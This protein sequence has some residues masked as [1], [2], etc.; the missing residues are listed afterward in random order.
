MNR[1]LTSTLRRARI[2]EPAILSYG[3]RPFFFFASVYAAAA[4]GLWLLMLEGAL[5]PPEGLAPRD[6]HVHE[7][8]FGYVPAVLTGFLLTAIPNWTGRLPIRGWPLLGLIGLWAAGR[9]AVALAGSIGW[10]AAAAIDGAFLLA[11]VAA[12][13]REIVAGRNLKNLVVVAV[14]SLL[15]AANL[16]FHLEAHL[17]G[18][19]ETSVRA[20]IA[21][22]VLLIALIGGRIIP[23]FTLNWLTRRGARHAPAPFGAFDR[24][25]IAAA[26]AALVAWVA[27]V[28][29]RIVAAAL[30]GAGLL[31]AARLA[32]WQGH[33]TAQ[34]PLLLVL[35]QAYAFIP[36]G[37]VLMGLAA[38][39]WI[40]PSAGI[41]AWTGGAIGTMTLAVMSRASLGHTGRALTASTATQLVYGLV[42]VAALAR[43]GAALAPDWYDPLIML[44]GFGWCAAFLLF[45]IIYA[46]ILWAP[47]RM[48]KA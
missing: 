30:M 15:A 28:D 29:G 10:L 24:I 3:F 14:V 23:S 26:A 47:R 37:F 39:G 32:R 33:R 1:P 19:A 16:G 48:A 43:I 5:P 31:H 42:I 35:H 18:T 44:A 36:L 13:A 20:G 9:A 2:G 41:H 4:V 25:A 46:P 12:A 6:W 11:V 27:L 17:A 34:E 8:L 22:V 40:P 7:M 21:T 45:A 38:A